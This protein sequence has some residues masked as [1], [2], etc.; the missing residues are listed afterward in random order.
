MRRFLYITPYFP[1][2]A[3]VGSLRPLKFARHLPSHDW[4]P[5]VLCDLWPGAKTDPALLDAVPET[6]IVVRDYSWRAAKAEQHHAK[7]WANRMDEDNLRA[8][9]ADRENRLVS[10]MPSWLNNPE[11][12]PLGEHSHRMPYALRRA[13][14]TLERFECEAIVV[15]ADPYAACLVGARLKRETGLP[16]IQDLRDPWAICELRRARRPMPVRV[17]VDRLERRAIDAADAVILNTETT[18][19][20]YREFYAGVD[21]A[22]FHWIRNHSDAALIGDGTHDGFDRFT[23]LFL[24]NFGRFIKAD[25]LLNAL[26][27][28]KKRGYD[29]R[30]VQMVVTGDFPESAWHMAQG[31]GVDGMIHLHPHV[32]YQQIGAVMNAADLLVLLIQPRG[33]QRLAAKLFDY[34]ASD[35]PIL[36]VSEN[37][38]LGRLLAD[39]GAGEMFGYAQFDAIAS[40]IVAEIGKGRQRAIARTPTGVTSAEAAA[41]LAGI[42]DAVTA[43]TSES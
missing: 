3:Q 8:R 16:L 13:H 9:R 24:G 23:L 40:A 33:R 29:S 20:D 2:Q 34:L 6:T 25:V 19:Q 22:K 18:W 37:A 39:S 42:L 4:A 30:A 26:A 14:E 1:P 21:P 15:N 5:V 10:A 11:L 38:E 35:R 27:E 31:L 17:L 7:A 32:P 12:V 28:V 43:K 41:Q 36:A